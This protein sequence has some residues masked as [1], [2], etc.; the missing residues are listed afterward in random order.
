MVSA[1]QIALAA[2]LILYLGQW[3]HVQA[4]CNRRGWHDVVSALQAR[5]WDVKDMRSLREMFSSAP[6]LVQIA[7]YAADH[8]DRPDASFLEEMRRDAF[9][10]R[11]AA[12]SALAKELLGRTNTAT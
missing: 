7:D 9:T 5:D 6:F 2:S 11:M 3:R 1:V 10:I 4:K 8:S 12:L